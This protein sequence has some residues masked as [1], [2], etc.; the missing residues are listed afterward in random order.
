MLSVGSKKYPKSLKVAGVTLLEMI[1]AVAIMSVIL[2]AGSQMIQQSV[3]MQRHMLESM[4][5]A[6]TEVM[7]SDRLYQDMKF[8]APSFNFLMRFDDGRAANG[9]CRDKTTFETEE[10]TEEEVKKREAHLYETTCYDVDTIVNNGNN[11][12]RMADHDFYL[13]DPSCVGSSYCY[14]S[15]TLNANDTYPDGKSGKRDFVIITTDTAV[16]NSFGVSAGVE[17]YDPSNAFKFVDRG[18]WGTDCGDQS[19]KKVEDLPY[20]NSYRGLSY[21]SN[22]L[23]AFLNAKNIG[24]SL[25][26]SSPIKNP[27]KLHGYDLGYPDLYVNFPLRIVS[28][29]V[30]HKNQVDVRPDFSLVSRSHLRDYTYASNYIKDNNGL[31]INF[32]D[33]EIFGGLGTEGD[34]K[35]KWTHYYHDHPHPGIFLKILQSYNG[36]QVNY[37]VRPIRIVRYHLSDAYLRA[38]EAGTEKPDEKLRNKDPCLTRYIYRG[39]TEDMDLND[40]QKGKGHWVGIECQFPGVEQVVFIRPNVS[41]PIISFKIKMQS[42]MDR[43]MKRRKD[44]APAEAE[45]DA[46]ANA[47]AGDGA[48]SE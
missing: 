36:E 30:D 42:Q 4:D 35:G 34:F 17:F 23:P 9:L 32:H 22:K 26:L 48:S 45:E 44:L 8:A 10:L 28:T 38:Q 14:R 41:L 2:L 21:G 16:K 29:T 20:C 13:Y 7:L 5:A 25:L 37:L 46:D 3:K 1:I 12:N 19:G 43:E 6:S 47:D 39:S 40:S 31:E 18:N 11:G 24:R 33:E 27:T 15:V